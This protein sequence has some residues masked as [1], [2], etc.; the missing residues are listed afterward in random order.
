MKVK[1]N[2]QL[3]ISSPTDG[4]GSLE[5]AVFSN[6]FASIMNSFT[7]KKESLEKELKKIIDI[8]A[9]L[10]K[11]R[12]SSYTKAQIESIKNIGH[13][14]ETIGMMNG[15]IDMM[16]EQ[17]ALFSKKVSLYKNSLKTKRAEEDVELLQNF[18][19]L[20]STITK[21]STFDL[22]KYAESITPDLKITKNQ[23]EGCASMVN[24][25]NCE[26]YTSNEEEFKVLSKEPLE[27]VYRVITLSKKP[28]V[29][30]VYG[31][32]CN[33]ILLH[34]AE[35]FVGSEENCEDL[36]SNETTLDEGIDTATETPTQV[37]PAPGQMVTDSE[38]TLT[39]VTTTEEVKVKEVVEQ[40]EVDVKGTENDEMRSKE[41][42]N[43]GNYRKRYHNKNFKK[44]GTFNKDNNEH[45][46]PNG[47][48]GD[49]IKRNDN[50]NAEQK[51]E[52]KFNPNN[53]RF[54]GES[55][56]KP[57]RTGG[58]NNGEK[59]DNTQRH[60]NSGRPHFNGSKNRG[61]KREQTSGNGTQHG[62]SN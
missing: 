46:K 48:R 40:K 39:E 42:G 57:L 34:F 32:K 38:E 11:G 36:K 50:E 1:A 12:E 7:S 29:D 51:G 5:D 24:Q 9:Q 14:S 13:L 17:S 58:E 49:R 60:Y 47:Y 18:M 30:D 23:I 15:Y 25:F 61:Q 43:K 41:Y 8:E 45:K 20:K 52:R 22:N 55:A 19:F 54:D 28:A 21:L 26:K 35:N 62:N 53:K 59:Y 16:K 37:T 4:S 56:R 33:Q 31:R 10:K 44:D 3:R 6:P 27:N 2:E